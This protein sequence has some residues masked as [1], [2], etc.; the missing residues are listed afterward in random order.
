MFIAPAEIA[1]PTVEEK[2]HKKRKGV[3]DGDPHEGDEKLKKKKK[4]K[5]EG[6]ERNDDATE[7]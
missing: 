1:A 7:P 3:A 6:G 5:K 4:K 2:R